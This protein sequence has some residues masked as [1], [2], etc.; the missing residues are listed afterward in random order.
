MPFSFEQ[1]S[2]TRIT[3]M[4]LFTKLRGTW[5]TFNFAWFHPTINM[6]FLPKHVLIVFLRLLPSSE[7]SCSNHFSW[8][9]GPEMCLDLNTYVAR[10]L[11]DCTNQKQ[12]RRCHDFAA[13]TVS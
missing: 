9:G 6:F 2:W 4:E 8:E 5:Y 11:M 7:C 12:N 1:A 10:E 3:E 13:I